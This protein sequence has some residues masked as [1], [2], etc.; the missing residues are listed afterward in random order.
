MFGDYTLYC[1]GK[2]VGMICDDE[3]YLKP[4]EVTRTFL[5]DILLKSPYPGAKPY[6]VIS[7]IDDRDYITM[8]VRTTADKL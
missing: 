8:L 7:D 4:L 6:Y 1:N 3:L 5:R 2:V